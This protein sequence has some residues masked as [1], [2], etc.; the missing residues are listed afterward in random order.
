MTN[1]ARVRV[2]LDV[3]GPLEARGIG[4]A[5]ADVA[6]LEG[7]ELLLGAEFVCLVEG[8]SIFCKRG[9][10]EDL[11]FCL[12]RMLCVLDEVKMEGFVTGKRDLGMRLKK[13][14]LAAHLDI[15]LVDDRSCLIFEL[16][17]KLHQQ[18]TLHF[19]NQLAKLPI[20]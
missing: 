13:V 15:A 12:V 7:L 3:G 5:G 18:G 9:G 10:E 8:V 20:P 11:P 6:G 19:F 4:V 17:L 14:G 2:A 16:P 1:I